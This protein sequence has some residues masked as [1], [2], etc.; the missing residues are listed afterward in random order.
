VIEGSPKVFVFEKEGNLF[1]GALDFVG[2][3][4]LVDPRETLAEEVGEEIRAI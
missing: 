4:I 2:V 1:E 3:G